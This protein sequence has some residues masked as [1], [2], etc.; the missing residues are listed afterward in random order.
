MHPAATNDDIGSS[1]RPS[2]AFRAAGCAIF[3]QR[4]LRCCLAEDFTI[5]P[6]QKYSPHVPVAR[7]SWTGGRTHMSHEADYVAL[8]GIDWADT[9]H[10]FCLRATG[11]AREE[12]GVMGHLA[13]AIDQWAKALAD[14][15]PG[16]KIAVCLEPSKGSLIYA[17]LKYDHLVLYPINLRMLAKFRDAL[18]PSGQKNDPA[19]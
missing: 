11:A 8:V 12:Y 5:R 7:S 17:L 2:K 18:A 16:R 10:D 19:D 9:K 14:R 3:R 13:E 15:F 4:I 1:G 6:S